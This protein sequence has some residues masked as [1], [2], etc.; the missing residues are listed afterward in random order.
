[1]RLSAARGLSLH[2]TAPEERTII[3][4]AQGMLL[5]GA[6]GEKTP[7]ADP[8]ARAANDALLHI[9]RFDFG[10]LEKDFEIYGQRDGA[11]WTLVLVARTEAARRGIGI[12]KVAGENTV[13]RHIELRHSA[14]QYVEIINAPPR[15]PAAFTAD[16]VKLFF[17]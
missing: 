16:E 8:R 2:Y 5:R 14:R 12:I 15:P 17:R 1:M 10:A 3:L 9:L 13:V 6:A 11:A 7:P 4:D